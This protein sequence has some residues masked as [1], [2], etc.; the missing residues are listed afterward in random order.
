MLKTFLEDCSNEKQPLFQMVQALLDAHGIKVKNPTTI[1]TCIGFFLF[2]VLNNSGSK[3]PMGLRHYGGTALGVYITL[4]VTDLVS[5]FKRGEEI[6]K[7]K[8]LTDSVA[9]LTDSSAIAEE[10]IP[11]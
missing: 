1:I 3:I 8:K 10:L 6:K 5:F 7:R 11:S 4:G 2:S 9:H